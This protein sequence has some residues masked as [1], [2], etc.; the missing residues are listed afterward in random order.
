MELIELGNQ[1]VEFE[2]LHMAD[3]MCLVVCR[4]DHKWKPSAHGGAPMGRARTAAPGWAGQP[5][6]APTFP[7][8]G[9]P[10]APSYQSAVVSLTLPYFCEIICWLYHRMVSQ[11]LD[12]ISQ[13]V[14]VPVLQ[15]SS[16]LVRLHF[17]ASMF[18]TFALVV[19]F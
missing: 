9:A 11:P 8:G 2:D 5:M 12:I 4:T 10:P 15:I 13:H 18:C 6:T 1:N 3:V 7:A 14:F 19:Y 16:S 17:L